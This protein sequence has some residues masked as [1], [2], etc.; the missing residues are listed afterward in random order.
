[1]KKST[2][3]II[4]DGISKAVQLSL[5]SGA[6]VNDAHALLKAI[7]RP[8]ESLAQEVVRRAAELDRQ[9]AGLAI[10]FQAAVRQCIDEAQHM[11]SVDGYTPAQV[12]DP[13]VRAGWLIYQGS[14]APLVA[15]GKK[16]APN[17][18]GKSPIRKVIASLLKKNPA[19][20]TAEIWNAVKDR[21]PHGHS[22]MEN[23]NGKY[24]EGPNPGQ[25][26]DYKR[27][28]NVCSEERSALKG[29]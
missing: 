6:T 10:S 15:K 25:N 9:A 20:K 5:N 29:A 22:V 14:A 17:G 26:M 28:S 4:S 21:P 3:K 12:R 27:F 19:M 7:A 24:I 11:A 18:R 16:F 13:L 23:R 1:M 8:T 2:R